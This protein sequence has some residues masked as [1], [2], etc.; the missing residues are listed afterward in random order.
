MKTATRTRKNAQILAGSIAALL[1][2]HS[3]R[4]A[5]VP[6]T[7]NADGDWTNILNWNAGVGPVPTTTD[8]AQF[9][10]AL[11][12]FGKHIFVDANRTIG[13]ISFGNTSQWGYT[14]NGGNLKLD[15]GGLITQAAGGTHMDTITGPIEVQG[16][17][18]TA[19]FTSVTGG[20]LNIAGAVTGV[21]TIGNTTTLT[22][23]GA[24]TG[25][26]EISAAIGDGAA[27]GKVAVTKAAAGNWYLSGNNNY[28]GTTT[29]SLGVLV[30]ESATALGNGGDIN[31]GGGT[32]QYQGQSA[33]TDWAS[34]FKSTAA[35][36]LVTNYQ[37]VTLAGAI[38]ATNTFG[39]SKTGTGTLTLSGANLYTGVTTIGQ[40]GG[41]LLAQAGGGSSFT[42]L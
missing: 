42:A 7:P 15:N 41:A 6:W 9:N 33:G 20:I 38:D 36:N 26:S 19:T 18:G 40:Q 31:F 14:L 4:A 23:N 3:A 39:L 22:L 16:D 25:G 32:L 34:R 5:V 30:A 37:D 12:L 21:S 17:G 8:T 13:T 1:A 35:I 29:I 28:T 24:G 27:G 10:T 11:T 2:A